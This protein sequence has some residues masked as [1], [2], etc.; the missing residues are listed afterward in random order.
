M[1]AKFVDCDGLTVHCL[2]T[3]ATTLPGVAP[4]LDRGDLFVLVHGAGRNAGDWQRQLD[5]LAASGHSTV[6]IDLPGHGRSPQT[7]GLSSLEAY[8][9]IVER[10]ADALALRP[11]VL[12]GWSMGAGIVLASAVRRPQRW[13]GLVLVAAGPGFEP[14]ADVLEITRDVV[15]GRRPQ[16]FDPAIFSPATGMDVRREVWTEQVKTDPRVLHGDLLAGQAF[17]WAG[18]AARI[19]RPALAVGGA[20]DALTPPARVEALARTIPGARAAVIEAAGHA[21]LRERPERLNAL[22]VEFAAGLP[23]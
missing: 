15:R 11:A 19:A 17:D 2:H 10:F 14:S 5:G 22:L 20:D 1:P 7:E 3:G 16:H 8:A 23:A 12:V 4:A 6:A 13:R 21:L 18:H 9:E